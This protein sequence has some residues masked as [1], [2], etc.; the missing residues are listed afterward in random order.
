MIVEWKTLWNCI[1]VFYFL[2]F[3]SVALSMECFDCPATSTTH[4]ECRQKGH[5]AEC[6]AGYATCFTEVLYEGGT[7][8][9]KKVTRSCV[10]YTFCD[11]EKKLHNKD[12]N[13]II[14]ENDYICVKCCH[15]NNCNMGGLA[16]GNGTSSIVHCPAL[17]WGTVIVVVYYY[18]MPFHG[19]LFGRYFRRKTL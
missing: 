6:T 14:R 11:E 13:C 3:I 16:D 15:S 12:G 8:Q 18:T 2:Q 17:L 10:D 19:G 4:E 5:V 1:F 9:T 7:G